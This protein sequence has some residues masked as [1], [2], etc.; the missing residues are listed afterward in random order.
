MY[1]SVIG[2]ILPVT[3]RLEDTAGDDVTG[4]VNANLTVKKADKDDTGLVTVVVGDRS[5]VELGEGDYTLN[6]DASV[7]DTLGF[8]RVKVSC[9]GCV[10]KQYVANVKLANF[11]D[12]AVHCDT[13]N[14]IAGSTYPTGT[15]SRPANTV[16]NALDIADANKLG[17]VKVLL[18]GDET[19]ADSGNRLKYKT[20]E[21]LISPFRKSTIG[22][23]S[24][25]GGPASLQGS[26]F[27][28]MRIGAFSGEGQGVEF[29]D[30]YIGSGF[31]SDDYSM[32]RCVLEG[33]LN[34]SGFADLLGCFFIGA[35]I[36]VQSTTAGDGFNLVSCRGKIVIKNMDNASNFINLD[37]FFGEI[38]IQASCTLGTIK[39][40]G[41]GGKL[42]NNTGGTT[43]EVNGFLE[44]AGCDVSA[45]LTK[46]QYT[47]FFN[48]TVLSRDGEE[49]GQ[50]KLGTGGNAKTIDVDFVV[51]GSKKKADEETVL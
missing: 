28:R 50:Y 34:T 3:I 47:D 32:K 29:E 7:I 39:I 4:K 9:T 23:L 21:G 1:D 19:V 24:F 5:L 31:L 13:A 18:T 35:D 30:C 46:A 48:K 41:G 6:I 43:V 12:G 11:S 2:K 36:E 10:T 20:I 25:S 42:T 15:R 40:R 37:G 44:G 51:I 14:G 8:F 49:P 17:H 26:H 33:N 22:V 27:K 45:L 16:V 38:E